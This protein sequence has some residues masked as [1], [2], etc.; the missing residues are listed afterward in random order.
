MRSHTT[1]CDLIQVLSQNPDTQEAPTDGLMLA[2]DIQLGICSLQSR[3]WHRSMKSHMPD[4]STVIELNHI[5][6]CLETWKQFLNRIESSEADA[7]NF[8]R[9]QHW[10]MRFYYGMEDHSKSGWQNI[11]Y[12]R[13]KSLVYDGIVLYHLSNLHLYSNIRIL[14]QLSKDL[15]PHKQLEDGGDVYKQAHQRRNTYAKE[16]AKSSSSRRALCYAAAILGFYNDLSTPLIDGI[17]PI[18]YVTISVAALVVWAYTSFAVHNCEACIFEMQ[19]LASS[20]ELLTVELARWSHINAGSALEKEK[21]DWIEAG[22]S[23]IFLNGTVLCRCTLSSIVSMYQSRLPKDWDVAN[24]IAPGI[25][26][27]EDA[28]TEG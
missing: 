22:R 24:T 21:E 1:I 7:L 18:I 28:G 8:T 9:G 12:Y 15:M 6:K 4:F 20:G 14:S 26:Q 27:T 10:A 2:E 17:D 5:K 3:L 25:F 11:V 19:L 13:Q 16:W 23:T